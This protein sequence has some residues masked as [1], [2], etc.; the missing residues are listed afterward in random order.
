MSIAT[1]TVQFYCMT[2]DIAVHTKCGALCK[3]VY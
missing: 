3:T 1:N 2:S